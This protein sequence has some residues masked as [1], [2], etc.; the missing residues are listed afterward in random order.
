MNSFIPFST[1]APSTP[2]G[3]KA[4]QWIA[5]GPKR[6]LIGGQWVDAGSGQ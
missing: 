1:S 3:L 6:L 5:S 4:R 2:E